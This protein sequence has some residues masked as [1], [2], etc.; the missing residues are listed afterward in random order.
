[1]NKGIYR[2]VKGDVTKPDKAPDERIV[3]PHV[4]NNLGGWGAGVVLAISKAFGDFP[5]NAYQW[6]LEHSQ[7]KGELGN[8]Y[9]AWIN[10]KKGENPPSTIKYD[11]MIANMVAQKGYIGKN[12]PRPLRYD[13]LAK[14]MTTVRQNILST[15]RNPIFSNIPISGIHCPKF[16]GDLAGGNFEFIEELIKDCWLNYGIDV[17]VYEWDG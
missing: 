8:V 15:N 1:M 3:I 7:E 5:R 6:G 14:C 16:G 9:D 17:T 4:C 13:A 10:R 2:V 11:I 12:N